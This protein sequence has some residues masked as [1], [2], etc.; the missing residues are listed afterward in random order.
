M[1]A[2]EVVTPVTTIKN[3]LLLSICISVGF[4]IIIEYSGMDMEVPIDLVG[5]VDKAEADGEST[6]DPGGFDTA[7]TFGDFLRVTQAIINGALFQYII[8]ILDMLG[9]NS[10]FVFGIRAIGAVFGL[11][12]V[13]YLISN[14][15]M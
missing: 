8:G 12:A 15:S 13:Y 14:R 6:A 11:F 4:A 5:F 7:F 10:T 1:S 3:T 2:S 9:F